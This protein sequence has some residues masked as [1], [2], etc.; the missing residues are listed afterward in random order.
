MASCKVE[1]TNTTN[2]VI[3]RE[4]RRHANAYSIRQPILSA[5]TW[6]FL[7]ASVV[8]A[9]DYGDVHICVGSCQDVARGEE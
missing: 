1:L 4:L 5:I 2:D 8:A 7:G 9:L 3:A 6:A